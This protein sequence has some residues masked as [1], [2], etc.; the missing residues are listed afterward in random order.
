[1]RDQEITLRGD[2]AVYFQTRDGV[3]R[4]T[5]EKGDRRR[6]IITTPDRVIVTKNPQ[7]AQEPMNRPTRLK[8][9]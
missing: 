2:E 1:M 7:R 9:V 5:R 8:V 6:L 4:V 3:I